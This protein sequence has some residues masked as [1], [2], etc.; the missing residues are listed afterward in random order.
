L[1]PKQHVPTRKVAPDNDGSALL[2]LGS[3]TSG[4]TIF[5]FVYPFPCLFLKLYQPL[6]AWD[7]QLQLVRPQPLI[8]TQIGDFALPA[9]GGIVFSAEDV[10][11]VHN[12]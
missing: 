2:G 11:I 4:G 8:L 12:L 10:S 7:V 9:E 5:F 6:D 3:G 1:T